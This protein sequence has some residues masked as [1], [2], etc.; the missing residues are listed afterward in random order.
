MHFQL[1]TILI[2]I[3]CYELT[4]IACGTIVD[5]SNAGS[6]DTENCGIRG[7]TNA[8]N[9]CHMQ[10]LNSATCIQRHCST[11][12]KIEKIQKLESI[13]TIRIARK[14]DVTQSELICDQDFQKSAKGC[15][16]T[17]LTEA[18]CDSGYTLSNDHCTKIEQP[19]CIANGYELR[20]TKCE[21]QTVHGTA[22]CPN[23]YVLINGNQ[24]QS[25]IPAHCPPGSEIQ[26]GKCV[27]IHITNAECQIG[28]LQ[29]TQCVDRV[30]ATC[31]QGIL[32]HNKCKYENVEKP[33]EV[34]AVGIPFGVEQCKIFKDCPADTQQIGSNCFKI[35]IELNCPAGYTTYTDS[36][37]SRNVCTQTTTQTQTTT[38]T[39]VCPTGSVSENGVCVTPTCDNGSVW[40]NGA[41]VHAIAPTCG[42]GYIWRNTKCVLECTVSRSC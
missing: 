37:C 16:H 14:F 29:G 15:V 32:L 28:H 7:V 39:I 27:Q 19:V 3:T 25:I 24:C 4:F 22:R 33:R 2:I 13:R 23:G 26:N 35:D 31:M 18:H 12:C 10:C 21:Q 20:G 34:C 5:C 42:N 1:I 41:C 6:R 38:T 11:S 17:S 30:R 40:R 9:L 36:E 8:N